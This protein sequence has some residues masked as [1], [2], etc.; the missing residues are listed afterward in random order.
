MMLRLGLVSQQMAMKDCRMLEA[1]R[2]RAE[3]RG[4]KRCTSATCLERSATFAGGGDDLTLRN[5]YW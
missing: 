3:R 5:A 2:S 1:P 4:M